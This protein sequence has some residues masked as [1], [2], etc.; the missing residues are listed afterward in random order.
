MNYHSSYPYESEDDGEFGPATALVL[1]LFAVLLLVGAMSWADARKSR[2]YQ[3]RRILAIT[4]SEGGQSLFQKGR[5]D[6]TP[7]ARRKIAEVVRETARIAASDYLAH[8]SRPNHIQ[9]IGYAS[10]EG[11]GNAALAQN[12]ATNVRNY[13]VEELGVPDECVILASYSDSH[14][15]SLGKWLAKGNPTE[16]FRRLSPIEQRRELGGSDADLAQ[17]RRV[18]ILSVYHSDSTCRLDLFKIR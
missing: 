3:P 16:T 12:R 18:E 13:L 15:P 11:K 1:S 2:G 14:S 17:E 8:R 7:D 4:E 9:V 5:S 10:P 6:L